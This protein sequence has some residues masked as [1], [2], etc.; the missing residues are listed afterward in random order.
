MH[1]REGQWVNMTELTHHED[2][3]YR[4]A[5]NELQ[6]V[7]SLSKEELKEHKISEALIKETKSDIQ[8]NVGIKSCLIDYKHLHGYYNKLSEKR[9]EEISFMIREYFETNNPMLLI[10]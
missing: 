7:L 10:S 1:P 9:K 6:H 2:R 4:R 5:I 8:L 3:L